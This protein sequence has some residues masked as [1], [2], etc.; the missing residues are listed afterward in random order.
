MGDP[1]AEWQRSNPD[2]VVYRPA[3]DNYDGDN[4]HFLVFK[5]PKYDGLMTVWTQSSCEGFGDNHIMFSRSDASAEKWEKPR[6][7]FGKGADGNG[8]QASW[9]FPLVSRSGRIYVFATRELEKRDVEGYEERN[10]QHCGGMGVIYSDDNGETW[11]DD[12]VILPVRRHIYDHPNPEV[13]SNWIVWQVPIRDAQGKYFAGYTV[14]ANSKVVDIGNVGSCWINDPSCCFF[15]R[16]ENI[17]EDPAPKDIKITWLPEDDKGVCVANANVPGV[18]TSQEPATVVLPDGRLFVVMRTPNG[19]VYYTLTEDGGK[20]FSEPE[21]LLYHDGGE[22]I[23]HPMSPSPIYRVSEDKYVLLTHNN[24]GSRLWY[25][26]S[27][28][29]WPENYANYVRN[30]TYLLIGSYAPDKHQP[31]E[32]EE[33]VEFLNTGDIAVGPKQTAEIGTYPTL[34]NWKDQLTL[35]Y[36]DRKYY[37]L[38]KHV[39]W[40]MIYSPK[41][42]GNDEIHS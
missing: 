18:I 7:I 14:W 30:P 42:G 9:G 6:K 38:G 2:V 23:L 1:K 37:L 22:R 20:T 11:V 36:P 10:R 28:T 17:D 24:N 4:E 16:F 35:W 21:P 8:T 31:I 29:Y 27:E 32:F 34:M 13:P 25:N 3:S 12:G 41:K 40:D 39:S 5:S 26:S 15:M 19:C 33:P